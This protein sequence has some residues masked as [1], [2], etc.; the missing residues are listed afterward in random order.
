MKTKLKATWDPKL[1]TFRA[2]VLVIPCIILAILVHYN[3]SQIMEVW[4]ADV[5]FMGLFDLFRI[6]CYST[7]IVSTFKNRGSRNDYDPLFVR[8]WRVPWVLYFELDLQVLYQTC[9][10]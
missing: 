1:D 7:P 5:D 4:K 6:S 2:E 9:I 3:G 8:A 10:S